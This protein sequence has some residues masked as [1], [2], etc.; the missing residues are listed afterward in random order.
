[1]W[2]HQVYCNGPCAETTHLFLSV[3]STA[4][5]RVDTNVGRVRAV[6]SD[7]EWSMRQTCRVALVRVVKPRVLSKLWKYDWRD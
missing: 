3:V 7:L 6:A 4:L 5:W 1:M 2:P